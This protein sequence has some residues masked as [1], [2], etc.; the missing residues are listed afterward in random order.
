MRE[1]FSTG[2]WLKPVLKVPLFLHWF[3]AQ[4]GAKGPPFC[5]G[6]WLKPV[7]KGI[8]FFEIPKGI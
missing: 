8:D 5:T 7:L 3:V 2:L 1:L 4:T 6:S